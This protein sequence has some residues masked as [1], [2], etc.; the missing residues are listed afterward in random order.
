MYE[1]YKNKK[2]WILEGGWLWAAPGQRDFAKDKGTCNEGGH[3]KCH[4]NEKPHSIVCEEQVQSHSQV[5]QKISSN[6]AGPSIPHIFC[7]E[8]QYVSEYN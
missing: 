1:T 2:S 6:Y 3:N 7:F 5:K 4:W 8:K